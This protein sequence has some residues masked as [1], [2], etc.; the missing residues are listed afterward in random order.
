M[1]L[2]VAHRRGVL[3]MALDRAGCLLH[4]SNQA[5]AGKHTHMHL[6]LLS[7]TDSTAVSR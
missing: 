3:K 7:G 4:L 2:Q 1:M 6:R 5:A